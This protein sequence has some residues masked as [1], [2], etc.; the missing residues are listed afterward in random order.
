MGGGGLCHSKPP[1]GSHKHTSRA[2]LLAHLLAQQLDLA[3]HHVEVVLQVGLLIEQLLDAR[4]GGGGARRQRGHLRGERRR[5]GLGGGLRGGG[6]G[7]GG[8]GRGVGGRGG[9]G[10][11]GRRGGDLDLRGERGVLFGLVLLGG[12][13]V[14]CGFVES[15]VNRWGETGAKGKFKSCCARD[16]KATFK[17][18]LLPPPPAPAPRARASSLQ[19]PPPPAT[20]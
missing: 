1:A 15:F 10:G 11:G 20:R 17:V 14:G 3:V 5:L 16:L 12:R 8:R 7:G 9:A 13:R 18:T 2:R 4:V 6:G 19:T